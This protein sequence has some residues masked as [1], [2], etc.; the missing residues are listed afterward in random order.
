MLL[1][2]PSTTARYFFLPPNAHVTGNEFNY[3][4]RDD[5]RIT[6]KLTLNLGVHYEINT[7]YHEAALSASPAFHRGCSTHLLERLKESSSTS[8]M[9]PFSNFTS[10]FSS[11]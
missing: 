2:Y 10:A 3:Y 7:P 9:H 6:N 8:R 4:A 5:W 11:S 1:G